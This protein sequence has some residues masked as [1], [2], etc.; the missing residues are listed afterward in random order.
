MSWRRRKVKGERL[1]A[2]DGRPICSWFLRSSFGPVQVGKEPK[3]PIFKARH[4]E[5]L[6]SYCEVRLGY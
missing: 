5:G 2:P 1:T 4:R 6:C 3:R